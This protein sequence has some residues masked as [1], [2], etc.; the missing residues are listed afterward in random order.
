MA[1]SANDLAAAVRYQ[2]SIERT[3]Y[4]ILDDV[5]SQSTTEGTR[6]NKW[7]FAKGK[8]ISYQS[9]L[10]RGAFRYSYGFDFTRADDDWDVARL[11]LPSAFFAIWQ[12]NAEEVWE[13]PADWTSPPRAWGWE[14]W[15]DA[16]KVTQL[17]TLGVQG[18][19]LDSG[20]SQFF[21]AALTEA[22]HALGLHNNG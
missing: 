3:L 7:S 19:S 17:R 2:N 16:A 13:P 10:I 14:G 1:L 5:W 22:E 21:L 15:E 20:Y 9:P 12:E 11:G 6:D 8:G 4:R 18:S